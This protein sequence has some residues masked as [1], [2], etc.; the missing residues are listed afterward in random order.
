MG[1]SSD[2][3]SATTTSS[4]PATR[5]RC[6]GSFPF[7]LVKRLYI[8]TLVMSWCGCS[9]FIVY[10]ISKAREGNLVCHRNWGF[11]SYPP[12][13][14]SSCESESQ[15]VL[16]SVRWGPSFHMS[17]YYD[18]LFGRTLW[19]LTWAWPQIYSTT[20]LVFSRWR[21]REILVVP[22]SWVYQ[23]NWNQLFGSDLVVRCNRVVR[24]S[25]LRCLDS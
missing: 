7:T 5:T 11:W 13:L 4:K 16:L 22:L 23:G 15:Q 17:E 12:Q 25:T 18:S 1:N 14:L 10:C 19:R 2:S 21:K 8:M 3:T 9:M 20:C 24:F 6:Y